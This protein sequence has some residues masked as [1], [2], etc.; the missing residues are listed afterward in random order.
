MALTARSG[1]YR[2]A[3]TAVERA[4][5]AEPP[6]VDHWWSTAFDQ[7]AAAMALLDLEGRYVRVNQAFC[8]LT[9]YT[10][11]QL[12]G[13]DFWQLTHP[14]DRELGRQVVAAAF[15]GEQAPPPFE[16]RYLLADG[17]TAWV[18]LS[19]SLVR[20]AEG[21]PRFFLSVM[22]DV[23]AAREA[24]SLWQ[25]SFDHAP[26]GMGLV[27]LAGRWTGVNNALC[28]LLGYTREE[29]LTMGFSDVTVPGDDTHD[30]DAMSDLISGRR[31]SVQLDK[32]YR[33]RDGHTLW[34]RIL[35]T[36][37]PGSDGKT[38]YFVAQYDDIGERRM[39][40]AR[41]T[42]MALHDPLTGLANRALLAD[43]LGQ[44]LAQLGRE[45]GVLAALV[46][47]LDGLKAVND[48]HGHAAGDQL[49]I[50]AARELQ[51][52]VRSRD[53]VARLGGDEF[54]V[55]AAHS[56]HRAARTLAGRLA[57]RLDTEVV[58]LGLR[59]RLHASVGLA[60]T[61]DPG[62]D[63][64]ALVRAADEEMYRNKRRRRHATG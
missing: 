27:N 32:R 21:R 39:A 59:L 46:V 4:R 11:E 51:A 20:D 43:R 42:R 40:D 29:L 58:A 44:G 50:A 34:V 41:L 25:R 12:H 36:A 37:V 56:S 8:T 10:R 1:G 24:R 3:M 55:L 13:Q 48:R 47:D 54:V 14:E 30:A 31:E 22:Q 57:A 62:A 63:P 45:G 33:H 49:L 7:A 9:G 26:I 5:E 6:D 61:A 18:L 60:S 64:E 2:E 52:A 19:T 35:A 53:T 16:K 23:T 28:E 38:A 15:D 17:T